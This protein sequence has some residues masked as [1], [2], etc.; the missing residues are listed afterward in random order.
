MNFLKLLVIISIVL[1]ST[2]FFA[3]NKQ[4]DIS[5]GTTSNS[6]LAVGLVVKNMFNGFG[7][8]YHTDGVGTAYT[9]ETGID[10]SSISDHTEVTDKGVIETNTYGMSL[11]VTYDLLKIFKKENKGLTLFIG[12]GYAVKEQVSEKYEYYV[13]DCCPELNEGNLITWISERSTSPIVELLLGYDFIKDGMF[14]L[15]LTMGYASTHGVVGMAGIGI[16]L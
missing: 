1:L 5:V 12:T 6:G 4:L 10:Y 2:Q 9:G 7:M 8:Y 13:W 15:N 14:K 16:P 11:G 3:Q